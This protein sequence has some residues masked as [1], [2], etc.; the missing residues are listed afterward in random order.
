MSWLRTALLKYLE[1]L[2][3][4]VSNSWLEVNAIFIATFVFLIDLLINT[5]SGNNLKNEKKISAQ[6]CRPL[7]IFC[8]LCCILSILMFLIGFR[9]PSLILSFYAILLLMT[10]M[11]CW[12]FS[13]FMRARKLAQANINVKIVHP[14]ADD[15]PNSGDV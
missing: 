14:V 8:L 12:V 4:S 3:I 13:E 11:L 7:S 5:Y 1:D 9:I 15:S 2:T 6:I 10:G